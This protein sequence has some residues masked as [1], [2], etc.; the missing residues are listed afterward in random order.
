MSEEQPIRVLRIMEG[1]SVDGPGLRTSVYVA[2]CRHHC[3]ECH[4]PQTWDFMAGTP[5]T[6]DEIME[7]V[8]F[9]GYGVTLTGG[10]PFFS[11]EALL[12]LIAA[13]HKELPH[14]PLWAYS[15]FT[16]EELLNHPDSAVRDM[17]R[18]V[19]VL[20][21]GPFRKEERNIKLRF[22]GSE[23]QRIICVRPSLE[24]GRVVLWED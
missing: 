4:N 19:D 17:L 9:N 2:G 11:P 24:Q 13:I 14:K 16:F 1:T 23:N 8:R 10:D 7:V 20:V 12:P 18:S 22:R 6:V 3:P 5:M 15:G 21:D